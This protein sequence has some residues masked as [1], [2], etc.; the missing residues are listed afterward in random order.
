[1]ALTPVSCL[2]SPRGQRSLAGYSPWCRT[3]SDVT[4]LLSTAT[5]PA[6]GWMLLSSEE[7]GTEAHTARVGAGGAAAEG[8]HRRRGHGWPDPL[9][10]SAVDRSRNC[11]ICRGLCPLWSEQGGALGITE[12]FLHPDWYGGLQRHTDPSS[13]TCGNTL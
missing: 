12:P 6:V 3:D 9:P 8:M 5:H 10:G 13:Q 1:M 4:E 7:A 11:G 2:E